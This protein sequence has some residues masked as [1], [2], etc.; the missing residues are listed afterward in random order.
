MPST[1]VRL[2][3]IVSA[4]ERWRHYSGQQAWESGNGWQAEGPKVM[5]SYITATV[6]GAE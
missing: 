2:A 5:S 1:V 3:P 4:T 6:K